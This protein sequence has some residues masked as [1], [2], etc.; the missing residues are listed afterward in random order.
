MFERVRTQD[1]MDGKAP[2]RS[3]NRNGVYTFGVAYLPIPEV[4]IKMDHTHTKL[5]N[6]STEVQFNLGIAYMF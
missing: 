5:E 4:A 1:E 2:D 3:K 6:K